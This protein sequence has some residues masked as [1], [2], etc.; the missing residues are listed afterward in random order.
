MDKVT[1]YLLNDRHPDGQSKAK[2]LSSFG[3]KI[4]EANI[5]LA[6]INA[7]PTL[8]AVVGTVTNDYGVKSIVECSIQTPDGRN[9]C[10]RSVWMMENGSI[11]QRFVTAYPSS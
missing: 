3:F 11:D 1:K 9:P 10:I 2:F 7:H 6:A 5:L 4:D 8:N